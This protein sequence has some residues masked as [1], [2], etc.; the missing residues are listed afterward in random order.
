MESARTRV[1]T[2]HVG[3]LNQEVRLAVLAAIILIATT[4]VGSSVATAQ[5]EY[6]DGPIAEGVSEGPD[7]SRPIDVNEPA[8]AETTPDDVIA[9]PGRL[10]AS[11]LDAALL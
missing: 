6:V 4:F 7:P 8:G 2:V 11:V 1:L 10:L 9:D 3:A 5:D